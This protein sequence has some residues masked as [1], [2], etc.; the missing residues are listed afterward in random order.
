MIAQVVIGIGA[1][2][3]YTLGL[4]YLD[5]IAK[6]KYVSYYIGLFYTFA[7][8]GPA[9]GFLLSSAFLSQ[10]VDPGVSDP[11]DA[12][13]PNFVGRWWTAYVVTGFASV[14]LSVPL[15]LFPKQLPGTAWIMEEKRKAQKGTGISATTDTQSFGDRPTA[16]KDLGTLASIKTTAKEFVVMVK[17]VFLLLLTPVLLTNTL[18]ATCEAFAVSRTPSAIKYVTIK[19]KCLFPLRRTLLNVLMKSIPRA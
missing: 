6:P 1:L 11:P 17:L 7:G 4:A 15:L 19:S 2:P 14:L 13:D 12:K 9:L 18:A 3:L 5:E 16:S 10:Y 8:I